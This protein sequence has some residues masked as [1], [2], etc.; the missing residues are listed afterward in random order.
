MTINALQLIAVIVLLPALMP[1][2]AAH[3]AGFMASSSRRRGN[4]STTQEM[5]F[6]GTSF[7]VVNNFPD[8]LEC[9]VNS[10]FIDNVNTT[11][12]D[13]K[14]HSDAS[15]GAIGT[16]ANATYS[17]YFIHNTVSTKI[18]IDCNGQLVASPHPTSLP[19]SSSSDGLLHDSAST[20]AFYSFLGNN[21]CSLNAITTSSSSSSAQ[22][23]HLHYHTISHCVNITIQPPSSSITTDITA[24]PSTTARFLHRRPNSAFSC[25]VFTT[26]RSSDSPAGPPLFT[27]NDTTLCSTLNRNLHVAVAYDFRL[28]FLNASTYTLPQYLRAVFANYGVM[29]PFMF[30]S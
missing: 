26:I 7:R 25:S 27:F 10:T 12:A 8:I 15:R 29:F 2:Q 9:S 18:L 24:A 13:A 1:S 14:A 22:L 28:C 17:C 21:S 23:L 20:S 6:L 4:G 30:S 19:Y 3:S 16:P 5:H 11:A